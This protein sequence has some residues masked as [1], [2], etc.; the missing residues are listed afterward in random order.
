MKVPTAADIM[1][2]S[3]LTLTP[4]L[5]IGTAMRKMLRAPSERCSGARL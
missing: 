5:D 4:E 3:E 1:D 2:R